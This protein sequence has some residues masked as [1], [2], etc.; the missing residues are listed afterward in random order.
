M[1]KM[2]PDHSKIIIYQTADGLTRLDVRMQ[3]EK[4]WFMRNFYIEYS[5][6]L[7]SATDGCRIQMDKEHRL[8]AKR[9]RTTEICR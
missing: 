3:G 7:N 8:H 9:H 4:L 1:R 6:N 2:I 5:Q